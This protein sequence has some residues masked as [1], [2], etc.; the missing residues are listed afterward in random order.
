MCSSSSYDTCISSSS[1]ATLLVF[2][3]EALDKG[4]HVLGCIRV[5]ACLLCVCA[6]TRVLG[7]GGGQT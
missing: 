2:G 3:L 7:G 1:Y 4:G 6:R 5:L